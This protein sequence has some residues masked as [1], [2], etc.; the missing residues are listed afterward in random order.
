MTPN[1]NEEVPVIYTNAKDTIVLKGKKQGNVFM[2]SGRDGFYRSDWYDL[3]GEFDSSEEA[4][5]VI[6][7]FYNESRELLRAIHNSMNPNKI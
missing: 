3:V 7:K 1:G 2:S 5:T 4:R 6:D